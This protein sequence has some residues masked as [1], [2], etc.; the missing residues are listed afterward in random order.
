VSFP[1]LIGFFAG[2]LLLV[3]AVAMTADNIWTFFSI[4]SMLIVAGGTIA[5]AFISYE[6]RYVRLAFTEMALLVFRPAA[7]RADLP[8][9]TSRIV[10]WGR[11]VKQGGLVAL[12]RQI[13]DVKKPDPFLLYG[14]DLL[15]AGYK[16]EELRDML[17]NVVDTTFQRQM[18]P[19]GVLKMMGN[20]APA[21]G[22]VGTL[23]GLIV[24]LEG[25]GGDAAA[26]GMGLAVA[27]V[28]TLYGVLLSRLVLLPAASKAQQRN[29]ISRFKNDLLAE[30]FVLLAE[31]R[32]PQFISDRMNGYLD[33]SI[34]VQRKAAQAGNA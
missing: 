7:G 34:R 17:D 31:Q 23:I 29:E 20:A 14:V 28:T 12:E 8:A 32:S 3:G 25:M 13:K 18:V 22:M 16:P 4:S 11:V 15:I 5:A 10:D 26:M 27:L 33:P 6:A 1:T 21:F 2:V 9:V 30:G 24:M 19:V